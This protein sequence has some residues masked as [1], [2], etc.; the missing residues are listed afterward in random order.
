M[1]LR[2]GDIVRAVNGKEIRSV[3]DLQSAVTVRARVWQVTIE[4]DGQRITA[5]FRG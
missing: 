2:P 4:R 5:Q 1:G 3:G